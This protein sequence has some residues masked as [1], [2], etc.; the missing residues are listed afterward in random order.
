M[1]SFLGCYFGRVW[2]G[3]GLS[4]TPSM[5]LL[6]NCLSVVIDTIA[7]VASLSFIV[8]GS[9]DPGP[10]HG[11]WQQHAR[12]MNIHMVSSISTCQEPPPG[13]WWQH[14]PQTSTSMATESTRAPSS[15]PGQTKDINMPSR[16]TW[17]TGTNMNSS[18]L[19]PGHQHGLR[20]QH[21]P[22][23]DCRDEHGPR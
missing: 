9:T 19:A 12:T 22:Q 20:W 5:S 1:A 2:G 23:M 7:K 14:G 21:R 11:F 4:Q 3:E 6:L 8:S 17:A 18:S 13:L 15:S 16:A 10:L